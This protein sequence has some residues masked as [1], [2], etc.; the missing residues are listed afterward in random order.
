ML[1]Q[2]LFDFAAANTQAS[3]LEDNADRIRRLA[4]N[5]MEDTI[6]QL[7][8][9]WQGKSANAYLEKL[10]QL[11]GSIAQ[12]A[13]DIDMIA[14]SLRFRARKIREAEEAAIRAAQSNGG[15]GGS[16]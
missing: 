15:G 13:E 1:Q 12:A 16:W 7:S 3:N 2:I 9:A 6:Q 4:D 10:R 11:Q 14:Q 8:A 5:K